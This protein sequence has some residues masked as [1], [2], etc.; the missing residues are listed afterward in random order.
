ME[1]GASDQCDLGRVI[2]R[3]ARMLHQLLE[4]YSWRYHEVT[5]SSHLARLSLPFRSF[6]RNF[7][8]SLTI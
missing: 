6:Q 2:K 3:V 1:H 5:N 4:I 8:L 7:S